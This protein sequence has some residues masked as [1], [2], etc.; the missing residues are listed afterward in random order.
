MCYFGELDP[1]G[2]LGYL[3]Q[4]VF[5]AA[6]CAVSSLGLVLSILLVGFSPAYVYGYFVY[7]KK[8]SISTLAGKLHV[9]AAAMMTLLLS[10][11]LWI[12][13]MVIGMWG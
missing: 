5:L 2:P 11:I 1:L 4:I 3:V 9:F 8:S 7:R 12:S 6:G 10:G 13:A